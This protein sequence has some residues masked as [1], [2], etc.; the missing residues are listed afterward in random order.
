MLNS[1][2]LFFDVS[3]GEIMV[4]M[5]FILMFFGS[6]K[7][8]DLARGLGKTMREFQNASNGIKQ[9][10]LS[11]ANKLRDEA[12][13]IQ[14]DVRSETNLD[15]LNNFAQEFSIKEQESTQQKLPNSVA[16][17][18]SEIISTSAVDSEK[19]KSTES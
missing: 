9:E 14:N 13:K 18:N 11:E 4:I 8:P 19:I 17:N 3:G 2:L 16:I 5:L 15:Q 1:V 6:K 12:T 10:L 7:I